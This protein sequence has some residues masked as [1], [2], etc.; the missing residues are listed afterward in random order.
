MLHEEQSYVFEHKVCIVNPV[1]YRTICEFTT[2][3]NA[4]DD[5]PLC[6]EK[7][8]LPLNYQAQNTVNINHCLL[9]HI[10]ISKL[11]HDS[12]LGRCEI[13]PKLK[14]VKSELNIL[15]FQDFKIFQLN[16]WYPTRSHESHVTYL[17]ER[18]SLSN[19]KIILTH[20]SW[21]KMAD[22]LGTV[23]SLNPYF[24]RLPMQL[25]RQ[26]LVYVLT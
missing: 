26:A 6:N 21:K 11:G 12:I 1:K 18:G 2:G 22:I 23:T 14:T 9:T 15:L 3:E 8:T 7:H 10:C 4:F 13:S 17:N 20:W 16:D 5:L 24:I 19:K 25:N